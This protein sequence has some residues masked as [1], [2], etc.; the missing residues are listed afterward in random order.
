MTANS[1]LPKQH[2]KHQGC[3]YQSGAENLNQY[4]LQRFHPK[5]FQSLLYIKYKKFFRPKVFPTGSN[6][7]DSPV[8]RCIKRCRQY[9]T[10]LL[11][12]YQANC[13]PQHEAKIYF[14]HKCLVHWSR[15]TDTQT[16]R[17]EIPHKME[18]LAQLVSCH[19]KTMSEVN[20][21]SLGLWKLAAAFDR[22]M[23]S[24]RRRLISREYSVKK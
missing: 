12:A 10:V 17:F 18:W 9:L 13:R 19:Q 15:S 5:V 6:S 3:L 4:G 14:H 23:S 7:G 11:K 24:R 8:H 22:A 21:V 20:V 1:D 2:R 16:W